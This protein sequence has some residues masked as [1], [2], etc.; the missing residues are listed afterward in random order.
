MIV[1]Q[2]YII[3][4]LLS[5]LFQDILGLFGANLEKISVNVETLKLFGTLSPRRSQTLQALLEI[6]I[7][8]HEHDGT[9]GD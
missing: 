9:F 7:V 1:F 5:F 3:F 4:T 6:W 8:S 2:N